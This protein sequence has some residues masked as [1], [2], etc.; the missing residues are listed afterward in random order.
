MKVRPRRRPSA[1]DGDGQVRDG[2]WVAEL[3]GPGRPGC[4]SSPARNARIRARNCGSPTSAGTGSPALPPAPG[5][6]SWLTWNCGT[7]AGPGARTGS[8][9]PRTPGCATC[10]CTAT[11]RNQIW[12][13]IVALACELIAWTQMLALTGAARRWEPKKLRLRLFCDAG[14][15]VRSRRRFRLRLAARWPWAATITVAIGRL[16][17]LAPG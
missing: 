3:T 17:A 6:G 9:A 15:I 10:R 7:A 2:A 13:Q 5:P 12:C 14:R 4:G 16:Q 8:A 11:S 1:Y